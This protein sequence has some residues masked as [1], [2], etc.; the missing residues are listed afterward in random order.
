MLSNYYKVTFISRKNT[1]TTPILALQTRSKMK[2]PS[3]F[4][5]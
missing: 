4:E 3:V 1:H 5:N 2:T